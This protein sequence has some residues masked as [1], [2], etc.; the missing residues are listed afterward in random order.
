MFK[1]GTR[2]SDLFEAQ[3]LDAKGD[4][5]PLLM[6]CYGIGLGRLMGCIVE[7]CHDDR[8]IVWPLPVAPYHVALIGL[9]LDKG[10]MSAL[11]EQLYA[12]LIA[13]GVEVLFDDRIE[14]A[15]V[16][17]NDA[18]LIGLPLRVVIS[19]RSL[20]NGGVELKLRAHKENRIIPVTEAL[21]AI[22]AEIRHGLDA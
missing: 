20:K 1:L 22:Q 2:Y 5:H 17:F 21:Q 18:D 14:S 15:G 11:A 7:Q 19:K 3:Y 16:K 4:M 9:D 13:A 12:G 6:G 10:E 8:G